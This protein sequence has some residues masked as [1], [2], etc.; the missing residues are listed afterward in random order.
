MRAFLFTLLMITMLLP[1]RAAAQPTDPVEVI[2]A[3]VAALDAHDLD[4]A[5]ELADEGMFLIL[6]SGS[7]DS[8]GGEITTFE[9]KAEIRDALGA[10]VTD[11]MRLRFVEPPEVM[12]GTT[13]WVERRESQ[14]LTGA[15]ISSLDFV[16]E[17][18]VQEG[19][20]RS[21]IYTPTPEAAAELA[22]AGLPIGLPPAG[23]PRSGGGLW[24]FYP[25]L[26]LGTFTL[27]AGLALHYARWRGVTN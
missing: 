19:K 23:M 14:T 17:A 13:I 21:L 16:G 1:S 9:G 7:E 18:L 11:N 2:E 22:R 26:F 5:M 20:I 25:W 4:A 24:R 3:W 8:E 15:G 27:L 6:L 12:E 10:Y